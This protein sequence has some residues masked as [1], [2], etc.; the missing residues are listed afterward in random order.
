[1]TPAL[2]IQGASKV[3]DFV[4]IAFGAK[5]RMR[6][7]DSD[8]SVGHA[9]VE[10]GDSVVM[11]SEATK[12]FPS[13]PGSIHLY[14]KDTDVNYQRALKAGGKSVRE[15]ADQFYGDRSA[16]VKDPGGNIWWIST[17]IEDVSQAEMKKRMKAR[18]KQ[19]R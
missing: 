8:G 6:M 13:M 14:V 19:P 1:M 18:A 7:I 3:I 9:E 2:I 12:D 17:H 10:I 11:I 15:P 16:G 5:E 4:A